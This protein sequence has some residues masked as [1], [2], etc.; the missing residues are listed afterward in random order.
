[1]VSHAPCLGPAAAAACRILPGQQQGDGRGAEAGASEKGPRKIAESSHLSHVQ[2]LKLLCIL[3]LRPAGGGQP[4]GAHCAAHSL[5]LQLR[6]HPARMHTITS[7]LAPTFLSHMQLSLCYRLCTAQAHTDRGSAHPGGT[8]GWRQSRHG[9][10]AAQAGGASGRLAA[11]PSRCCPSCSCCCRLAPE[12]GAAS[13]LLPGGESGTW[14]CRMG[15]HS[16]VAVGLGFAL[17][18][19]AGPNLQLAAKPPPA[20]TCSSRT[21]PTAARQHTPAR[22]TH[23]PQHMHAHSSIARR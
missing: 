20:S 5:S 9:S 15:P 2:A 4:L 11:S 8:V 7:L 17:A 1:M 16:N 18:G 13:S 14:A 19:R 22:K 12:D 23:A 21:V 10:P 3:A 6:R